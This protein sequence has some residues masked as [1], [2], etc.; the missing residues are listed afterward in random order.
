MDKHKV[1]ISQLSIVDGANPE[2]LVLLS[3]MRAIYL[4]AKITDLARDQIKLMKKLGKHTL[5][6]EINLSLCSFP[7]D[8][9]LF[10][11]FSILFLRFLKFRQP[12]KV[13]NSETR[14]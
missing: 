10:E 6:L 9:N 1:F 4:H 14:A 12:D 3:I 5:P 2:F 7:L 11:T 8:V 13:E